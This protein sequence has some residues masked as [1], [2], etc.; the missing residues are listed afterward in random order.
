[1]NQV[2]VQLLLAPAA[3]GKTAYVIDAIRALPP[4]APVRVLAPD[5][6]Q[7]QALR[8]RLAQ[9]GGALGVEVQ[10]FY[11]L[12]ADVL[13]SAS[14]THSDGLLLP[15]LSPTLQYHLIRHLFEA[16]CDAGRLPYYAPLRDLPGFASLLGNLFG[17]LKCARVFPEDLER[18]LSPSQGESRN[19]GRLAEL[20]RLYTA[21]Q[22][23]LIENGWM[24]ADGQGWLAAIALEENPTLLSDLALLA[25][26]GFDEF[27]PTQ[28]HV[29]RLLAGRAAETIVTLT[30]DPQN[31]DR[32]ALSRLARARAALVETLKTEPVPLPTRYSSTS[33]PLAHLE[34]N[35]FE[36]DVSPLA[37][38][39][40]VTFLEA[41]NRA[42]E[43][44]EALRW[45]KGRIVRERVP[46][47]ETAIVARDVTPYR[48]FLEEV[49][50]EFGMPLRFLSGAD[51]RTNPAMAALLNLLHLPLEPQ[52]WAPR[53]VLDALTSPYFDWSGCGLAP[54]D[55]LRLDA[56]ARALKII[57]GLEQWRAAFQ[58]LAQRPPEQDIED[59]EEGI[60]PYVPTGR[61][62]ERLAA[63]FEA[64]VARI[65]PPSEATLREYIAWVEE[66]IGDDPAL[67]PIPPSPL[68][69]RGEKEDGGNGARSLRVV[70]RARENSATAERDVAALRALKDILRSLVL[71]DA[72]LAAEQNDV[73][74]YN[75]F[76]AELAQ[77]I[78]NATYPIPVEGEAILVA[79]V[80]QV[81][82]LAF[83]SVAVLGL[84][85]GDFPCAEQ[86]DALLRES[87]RAWLRERGFAIEPRLQ[88]D[89]AT[90]FYHAVTRARRRLLLCR[91]YLADD[92]QP[93][94][95]SPYWEAVH[96][97]FPDAPLLHVRPTDVTSD[98]ASEQE[99]GGA[100]TIAPPPQPGD[101]MPLAEQLAARFGPDRPW[102]SSRLETYARCP[103]YFWAAYVMELKPHEPPQ[104]G[105]DVLI[106]GQI[107]HRVLERL[108]ACVP[109]GDP[110]RLRAELPGVAREVYDA[111]PHDYGF[112]PSSLW[113]RQQEELT[114]VLRRTLDALIEAAGEYRPLAQERPF[115]LEERPP[116]VLES[117]QGPVLQI[118]GYIDRIDQ[119]PDGRLRV[120]DY[121]AGSTAILARDL[122]EGR[123]LQLPLYALA[124][125][126]AHGAEVSEGFYW[127]ISSARP[128]GLRL[129]KVEGGVEGA[130]ETA[131]EHALE[132]AA[133]V[134]RGEFAPR[135]PKDGC[136]SFCPAAAFCERYKPKPR[137]W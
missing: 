57:G 31:L 52:A 63:A 46:L 95:P 124:A 39:D 71:A 6:V 129:E 97:L 1:M 116:L 45:L 35:L 11:D 5:R 85:E 98:P 88:G 123:R 74:P 100:V 134:R 20:A 89:E 3:C 86:E 17:E 90:F 4:L 40:A 58:T 42:A 133:A 24:D 65:T 21:Y 99:L 7:A 37:A 96:A 94:E 105:F 25:V 28:L 104:I 117:A 132:I 110:E 76:V 60:P 102:S 48:P 83:D 51:L 107:Y 108:Y 70:A 130:I 30:G 61:E 67:T 53:A 127:H 69:A 59:V 29:L 62:A 47:A 125:Q 77:S 78:E 103:F 112:R 80:L 38:D 81:R 131:V 93:W 113:E 50:A 120:I 135:P 119:A 22:T 121:K 84:A 14:S 2:A 33:I 19:E 87:D 43:A 72:L 101:L 55:P 56:A 106:L 126:K 79:S 44:R 75:Q 32:P 118:R 10:T 114:S 66:L 92:G 68:R 41:Q 82:G 9:A 91:P 109:D 122:A 49:A 16:L 23:W 128:S 26:D 34:Q 136:P 13:A 54:K 115:G 111:A 36:P 27:N 8:R 12:Y 18:A 64:I 73:L 15:R 137:T